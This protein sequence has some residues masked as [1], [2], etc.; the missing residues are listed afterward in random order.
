MSEVSSSLPTEPALVYLSDPALPGYICV[1]LLTPHILL[2]VLG[3]PPP[4]SAAFQNPTLSM[5]FLQFCLVQI[6]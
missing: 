4:P 5:R 3:I 6:V 1:H 2:W